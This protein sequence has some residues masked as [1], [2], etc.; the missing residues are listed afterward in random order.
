[1]DGGGGEERNRIGGGPITRGETLNS[2]VP[3]ETAVVSLRNAV[4]RY[5][6]ACALH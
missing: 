1:M 2:E 4:H 5:A 3:V 6:A